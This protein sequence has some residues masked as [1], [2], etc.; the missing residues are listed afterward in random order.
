MYFSIFIQF[1]PFTLLFF[2]K[3]KVFYSIQRTLLIFCTI[4]IVSDFAGLIL[5]PIFKNNNPIYHIYSLTAGVTILIIY[6][7]IFQHLRIKKLIFFVSIIFVILSIFFFF[8]K[9]G[10]KINNTFSNIALC[11][12]I[13]VLSIYYFYTIFIEKKIKVLKDHYFFWINCAFFIYYGTIFYISLFE[14]FIRSY[15][16]DLFLYI[17]PIQLIT[18]IIFNLI[19]AKGIWTMRK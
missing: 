18:T 10:Y 13:M 4:S 3:N 1:L 7:S 6:I 16:Y 17:W 9:D 5:A 14:N 2:I 8:Y 11:L 12:I 19:L 15:N